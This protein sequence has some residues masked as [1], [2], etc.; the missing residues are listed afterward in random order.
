MRPRTRPA[1]VLG[2]GEAVRW[3]STVCVSRPSGVRCENGATLH[4][5]AVSRTSFELF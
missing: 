5:F 3:G 2:Y 4:G 1:A